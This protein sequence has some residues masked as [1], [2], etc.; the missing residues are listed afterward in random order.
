MDSFQVVLVNL[1]SAIVAAQCGNLELQRR[2]I[3]AADALHVATA[4]AEGAQLFITTDADLIRL[5][6]VFENS[7]GERL[8][9]VDT[10]QAKVLLA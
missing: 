4:L 2:G 6:N 10:D 9:C 7:H 8:R 1:T 3:R 5:D